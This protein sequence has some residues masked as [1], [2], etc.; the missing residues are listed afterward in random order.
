[1]LIQSLPSQELKPPINSARFNGMSQ[2][3]ASPVGPAHSID[4][5]EKEGSSG[6][7]SSA[8]LFLEWG[9]KHDVWIRRN[10]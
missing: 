6:S 4:G 8:I 5:W 9:I 10:C 2:I 1:M 3:N 7:R